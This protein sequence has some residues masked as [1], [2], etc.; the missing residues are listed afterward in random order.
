V[1]PLSNVDGVV[2]ALHDHGRCN[3]RDHCKTGKLSVAGDLFRF[4]V[5]DVTASDDGRCLIEVEFRNIHPTTGLKRSEEG[6]HLLIVEQR[7]SLQLR[8]IL[9]F[10]DVHNYDAASQEVYDDMLKAVQECSGGRSGKQPS[11][12]GAG[13][14]VRALASSGTQKHT[15]DKHK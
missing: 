4:V 10:Q 13:A 1:K 11:A 15:L 6:G 7:G 9:D 3:D 2:L 8:H 14:G 12:A 5:P